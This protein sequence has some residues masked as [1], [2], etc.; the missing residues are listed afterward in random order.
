MSAEKL[1]LGCKDFEERKLV[2]R[3]LAKIYVK[4]SITQRQLLYAAEEILGYRLYEDTLRK[5][6]K[7]LR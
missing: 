6:I 4:K 7:E 5:Y 2:Y 3:L 1:N